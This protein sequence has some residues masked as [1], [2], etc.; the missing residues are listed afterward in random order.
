LELSRTSY[1][2]DLTDAEWEQLSPLVP[3]VQPGGRPP[4]HSRREILNGIFYVV[5]SGGAWKLLP[6]DLPPGRT[7]YHYFWS[8]RCAGIWQKIHDTLRER[9]REAAGRDINPS[10]ALLDS[11]SMR[12]SEA[13][14][15]RGYDAGKKIRGRKRHIL[16]DT[17]GLLLLVVVVTAA[18][19]QDRKGAQLLL[20]PLSKQFRRL[21]L[22][23]A[24]G[25]YAGELEAWTRNLRR[26]GKVR[27]EIVRK[28]KGQKGFSVLPWRWRVERTFA[29]LCRNRRLRCDYERLPQ[30]TESLIY[31]AMIRLMTRRLAA[32]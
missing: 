19:I 22:I 13:G 8:W 6:H 20:S 25:A 29:W 26:W 27:L 28:P 3:A 23:W 7:V 4:L 24:D 2:T 18:N 9:V 32:S 10:A 21:R 1:E 17:L 12:T 14:G 31:V 11:Q 30:T 15:V 16:V 5:R